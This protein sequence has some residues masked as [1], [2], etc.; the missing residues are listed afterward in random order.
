M[1]TTMLCFFHCHCR[2]LASGS[3]VLHHIG[4]S[5]A[6]TFIANGS[7]STVIEKEDK[8]GELDIYGV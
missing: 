7:D 1:E 5:R 2:S 4:N 6:R 3:L 8:G